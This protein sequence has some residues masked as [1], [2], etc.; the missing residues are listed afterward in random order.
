MDSDPNIMPHYIPVQKQYENYVFT[1]FQP[2][3]SL[4]KYLKANRLT[5][6][7]Q[8]IIKFLEHA[9]KGLLYL[10]DRSII[11][12]D[13]KPNNILISKDLKAKITDFGETMHL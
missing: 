8:T 13:F 3:S 5:L 1:K 2:H 7:L 6:N 9:I 11:H 4:E 10:K 12:L